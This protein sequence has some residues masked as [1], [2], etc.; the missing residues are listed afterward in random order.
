MKYVGGVCMGVYIMEG[1]NYDVCCAY[2]GGGDVCVMHSCL[3]KRCVCVCM[4]ARGGDVCV[5][6]LLCVADCSTLVVGGPAAGT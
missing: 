5:I 6:V 1:D 2:D 3:W 4:T